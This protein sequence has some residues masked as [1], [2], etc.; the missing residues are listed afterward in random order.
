MPRTKRTKPLYQRGP[1][2]LYP[3][4]GRNLEIVWY[5]ET[6]KRERS[7]SAGTGDVTKGRLALDRRCLA[8]HDT[9]YCPRCGQETNGE[10][11]P[12]LLSV[13]TDY[14]LKSEGQAGYIR[15]TKPRLAN[16]IAYVAATDPSV[17]VSAVNEDW[18]ER[19]REWL[20]AMPVASGRDRTLGGVEGCVLQLAAAINSKKA[21]SA[22]FKARSVKE[23]AKSPVYRASVATIA[24]MF[25]FCLYP[26]P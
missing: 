21:G 18:V 1:F 8:A 10:A 24:E 9:H 6:A 23:L 22:Q 17:T 14:M 7:A 13:I 12:L 3:R 15:S 25:R 11:V 4:E 5:D 2:A 16:V 26:G 19:F 20:M